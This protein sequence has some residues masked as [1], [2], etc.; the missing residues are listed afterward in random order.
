MC[1]CG[2]VFAASVV[3]ALDLKSEL[4][5]LRAYAPLYRHHPSRYHLALSLLATPPPHTAASAH[6]PTPQTRLLLLALV[7]PPLPPGAAPAKIDVPR[8]QAA[9]PARLL[10]GTL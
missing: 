8:E 7:S 6:L 4:Q 3:D 5:L 10:K 1:R 9:A 2:D